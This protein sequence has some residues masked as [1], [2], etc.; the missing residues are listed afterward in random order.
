MAKLLARLQSLLNKNPKRLGSRRKRNRLGFESL[1]SRRV[2]AAYISEIHAAPLFGNV[3]N[4]QY[5][6]LRG[7]PNAELPQGTYFVTLDGWSNP[8]QIESV[9]DL[10]GLRFGNNGFLVV[11]QFENPYQIDSAATSL[12]SSAAGFSGLPGNRWSDNSTLSDRLTFIFGCATFMLV[13][14]PSKPIPGTDVDQNNDGVRDGASIPWNELDSVG[15]LNSTAGVGVSYGKITFSE[16]TS[17]TVPAGTSLIKTERPIYAGRIGASMSWNAADWVAGNTIDDSATAE[18]LY[19]FTFGTFG[20]PSPLVYAGR[21]LNHVGTFNFDG[22]VRGTMGQDLD[23]DGKLTNADYLA[24]GVQVFADGN[25]NGFRDSLQQEVVA[26][27]YPERTELTNRFPNATL[28][29]A[30]SNGENIGHVVRTRSTF[31]NDFNVITV[32]SSEGIPWFDTSDKLKVLF[33]HEA[34]SVSVEAIAAENLKSS[35]GRI[36]IYDRNDQLLG[37]AQ[38]NALRGLQRETISIQRPQADI[39]YA[40]IFS[41]EEIFDSS[42]FGM[43]DRLLYTYPE[44]QT[45]SDSEGKYAI[46]ELS[47]GSY[48]VYAD[49]SAAAHI[50]IGNTFHNILVSKNEHLLNADFGFRKNLAPVIETSRLEIPENPLLNAVVTSIAAS[51]PDEGQSLSYSF[52]GN[53]GPFSIDSATGAVKVRQVGQWDF[54]RTLPIEVV[55][56]VTDSFQV[57]ASTTKTITIAPTDINEPPVLT[58]GSFTISENTTVGMEVG[59]LTATDPDAG[60]AG[61][62]QFSIAPGGPTNVFGVNPATGLLFVMNPSSIDF[63]TRA[64]W[65]IPVRVTDQGSPSLSSTTNVIVNITNVNDPPAGV[66]FRDVVSV[67]ES[68]SIAT[69]VFVANVHV[70]DDGLGMNAL[71]LSGTDAELFSLSGTQLSFK[72]NATLDFETK[73]SYVVTVSASDPA[74]PS[75]PAASSNFTLSITDSNEAPTSVRL[76]DSIAS[77]AESTNLANGLQVATVVVTDDALGLN[78]ILLSGPDA[79]QFEVKESGVWL[80]AGSTLDFESK[81]NYR[82]NVQVDDASLGNSHELS[83]ELSLSI[84]DANE[85]PTA[86]QLSSVVNTLEEM[87]SNSVGQSLAAITVTDDALGTNEI[88][89]SGD[90]ASNFEIIGNQLKLKAGTLFDFETKAVY[91]LVLEVVDSSLPGATSPKTNYRLNIT[92]RPEVIGVTDVSGNALGNQIRKARITWDAPVNFT[93]DAIRFV[94]AD[95]GDLLIPYTFEEFTINNRT[96]VDL[97]FTGSLVNANGLV[98]GTYR[99]LVDGTK[100]KAKVTNVSGV[101]FRSSGISVFSPVPT[102]NLNVT[103]PATVR[104]NESFRIQVQLS[105]ITPPPSTGVTY[106]VDIDG[107]GTFDRTIV[108]GASV[109]LLNELFSTPGSRSILVQAERNG[110]ILAYGATVIDVASSTTANENWL[111]SLDADRDNSVSP[112][113]VLAIINRLN[114]RPPNSPVPYQLTSDVDRDGS[115][116]PLDVLAV[117]NF[118]N[119]SPDQRIAPLADLVMANSGT[120]FGITND[121]SVEGKINSETT[122]LFASLNGTTKKDASR[123]VRT[124]GTFAIQDS[125]IIELFGSIP[126]GSHTLSLYTK[127][128]TSFSSAMDRRFYRMTDS[129]EDFQVTSIVKIGTQTRVQWSSA[130]S[131]ARYNVYTTSNGSSPELRKGNVAAR[132]TRLDLPAGTYGLI[133][134]AVDAAGNISRLPQIAFEVT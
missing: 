75:A 43:F 55:V 113:D 49:G 112:L 54:E 39:K 94:K 29:V 16:N 44:F 15:L 127:T 120:A 25:G 19:R 53:S 42:P 133:V 97:T 116:S 73:P 129:L 80:R 60:P 23:Q 6:E 27:N 115:I 61:T 128:G 48:T 26:I 106:K 71:A 63:E 21:S 33:Y 91:D 117:I 5:V 110:S 86:I 99:V 102:G 118:I 11:S 87:A 122:Q 93:P 130:G 98:D 100:T 50:P 89:I 59:T 65:T 96:Q 28:T 7:E 81:P 114:D 12:K 103:A 13:Q 40:L 107:D 56:K 36:E 105:G 68:T 108:G 32:L 18:E 64:T 35:F 31:D 88:R 69:P 4:D 121:L 30:A 45:T 14:A 57:P 22:G 34:D 82:F 47:A 3:D 124:D 72:P 8:G 1:E 38:T 46:E 66:Q 77:L 70:V 85:A 76:A 119:T 78:T 111:T 123:F 132:E 95:V 79:A 24:S 9:I 2:L 41:N 62:F 10:S 131:G 67:S 126:D 37:F 83:I 90:G 58:I 20:D 84:T 101:D 51:D 125:A 104:T 52:V 109:Q 74:F 17:Y 92:N 134:E